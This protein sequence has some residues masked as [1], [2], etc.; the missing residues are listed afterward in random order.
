M[1]CVFQSPSLKAW[2]VAYAIPLQMQYQHHPQRLYYPRVYYVVSSEHSEHVPESML[3]DRQQYGIS[4][5]PFLKVGSERGTMA[6][7][8]MEATL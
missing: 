1:Y 2:E 6:Q 4:R 8:D 3:T 5:Y 7:S